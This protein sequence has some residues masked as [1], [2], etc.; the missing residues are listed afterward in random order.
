MGEAS[1][2]VVDN[3]LDVASGRGRPPRRRAGD[4]IPDGDVGPAAVG[5][6]PGAVGGRLAGSGDLSRKHGFGGSVHIA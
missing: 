1:V 4:P 2:E 6:G 5:E 3:L